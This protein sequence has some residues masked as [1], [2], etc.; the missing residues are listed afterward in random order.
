MSD[1]ESNINCD[2]FVPISEVYSGS[3]TL[4]CVKCN[5]ELNNIFD[6][7]DEN[8]PSEGS[9][10]KTTGHYG[11]TFFDPGSGETL[12]VNIC[13]GCMKEL[14]DSQKVGYRK[15]DGPLMV[16]NKQIE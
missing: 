15:P 12:E 11:D 8:Q 13:S 5:K 14:W 16:K 7:Q 4:P 9:S 10:L 3:L 6:F 2:E 1:V